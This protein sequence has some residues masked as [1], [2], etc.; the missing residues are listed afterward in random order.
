MDVLQKSDR[1]KDGAGGES[2]CKS[3]YV[4][5]LQ[6]YIFH[7][8]CS[9]QPFGTEFAVFDMFAVVGNAIVGANRFSID[10][11]PVGISFFT[12]QAISCNGCLPQYLLPVRNILDFGFYL[13]TAAGGRSIVRASNSY[14]SCSEEILPQ[15]MVRY[16]GILDYQWPG[17]NRHSD[18]L[19]INFIDR[20]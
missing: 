11:L 7:H 17:E 4:M 8:G 18:Y 12:F 16:S 20:I 10:T 9:Q 2:D 15:Q 13:C 19:A 6:I 1:E 14:L 5:L 3:F